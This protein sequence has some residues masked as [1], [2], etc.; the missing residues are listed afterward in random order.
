MS[1][2]WSWPPLS[3]CGYLRQHLA[4]VEADRVEGPGHLAPTSRPSSTS[5]KN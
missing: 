5:G 2:R 1:I 3:W 4:G